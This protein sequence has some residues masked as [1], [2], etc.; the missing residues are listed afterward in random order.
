MSALPP[1]AEY[2]ASESIS[3]NG[4]ELRDTKADGDDVAGVMR[5]RVASSDVVGFVTASTRG[6]ELASPRCQW[7]DI[8]VSF[9]E[10]LSLAM[11]A[12]LIALAAA[13]FAPYADNLS[14]GLASMGH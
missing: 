1:K 8:A 7:E 11:A 9:R 13:L 12:A 14:V 3:A 5:P 2:S 10:F 6:R 4:P